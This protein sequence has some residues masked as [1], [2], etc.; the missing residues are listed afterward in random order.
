MSWHKGFI[1]PDE[2]RAARKALGW[3]QGELAKRSGFSRRTVAYH[4]QKPGGRID[5]VAPAAFRAVLLEAGAV[6]APAPPRRMPPPSP[7]ELVFWRRPPKIK[8]LRDPPAPRPPKLPPQICGARTRDGDPCKAKA[9]AGKKRCRN[10][11][12]LSTGPRT[13]EG[14]AVIAAAQRA[15]HAREREHVANT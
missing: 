8:V 10:H 1:G 13:V 7:F 6:L 12:G 3:S 15:R 4:E 5:G 14:L 11:G 2:L 9:V